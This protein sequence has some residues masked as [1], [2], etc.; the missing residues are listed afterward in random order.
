MSVE[1]SFETEVSELGADEIE[2]VVSGVLAAESASLDLSI[3]VV[4]DERIHEINRQFLEHDYPTDV[5]AFDLASDEPG[6]DG[7]IVVSAATARREAADRGINPASELLLY[8]VHGTLHL[9][10]YDDK[11]P[12]DRTRMHARQRELLARFGHEIPE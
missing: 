8:C 11:Q 5:I 1:V 10:G 6:V 3:V 7:E 2:R 4:D 12:Q 9:L